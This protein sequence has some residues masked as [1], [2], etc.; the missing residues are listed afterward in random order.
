MT[1]SVE[2]SKNNE[3]AK[4]RWELVPYMSGRVLDLGCGAYKTFPHFIGVD[5]G[6]HWGPMGVDVMVETCERLDLFASQ[7]VD[8]IFSSHLLEHLEYN[9]LPETLREW[10][11]VIKPGGHLILYLPDEDEYPKVGHP[12][13]NP[14]HKWDVSYEKV[15]AVMEQVSKGWDLID[16]QKRNETDEYSLFFV[17]KLTPG[18]THEFTWKLPKPQKTVAIT[19]FG[20]FGDMVQT[21]SLF[22]W[23][24][25]NGYHVTLYCQKGG[26]DVIKSDPHVDRFIV[27]GKDQI[28][29]TFLQEFWD[30]A[31]KKYDKWVNLSESVEATLLAE[32]GRANHEWPHEVRAKYMDRNYLEWTHELAQ[33]P[34][35]YRPKFYP[36][37]EER[38]WARKTVNQW[39]R[40]I[41]WSLSGSSVHK[42][43]PH[44]DAIVARVM[45]E[46]PDT[47]VVLVG[48]EFCR[49]LETGW[50]K[51]P[52]VHCK[53][54]KWSIRESMA[55]A[56]V[57]DLVIGTETG[58]LNA[59]GSMDV[60][61]IVTLSHSSEE[62]L[63]KHWKNVTALK[64]ENVK[65]YPC[66]QLHRGW[67]HCWKDEGTGTAMCQFDIGVEQM[68]DAV[69][70]VLGKQ[71]I[72]A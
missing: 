2:N 17:F 48:D 45:L 8:T 44:L 20:A 70:A 67:D 7:S 21:S 69:T 24:K 68:W 27:L 54:A 64:P 59:A 1:W 29:P 56:E 63:T 4:I 50:E 49:I 3:A 60:P 66:R 13:A 43:W 10:V 52:R 42:V 46:Y 23:L 15:V 62:M 19:R 47:H 38:A 26:Y 65:C 6:H 39:G 34:P 5:N 57:S 14:D 61:K 25:E 11:R 18:K 71:R 36:T 9:T 22:P 58:L 40:C 30:Y 28:P 35:P 33:V 72:A 53:S 32:P 16:Y 55:F 37:I 41:L 51:E 31:R 12:N